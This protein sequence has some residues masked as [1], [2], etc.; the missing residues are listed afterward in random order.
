[1]AVDAALPHEEVAH[2]QEPGGDRVQSC[3]QGRQ[4]VDLDHRRATHTAAP[5][6]ASANANVTP[7]AAQGRA[8]ATSARP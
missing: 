4:I 7:Q 1:V 3:V 8:K 6:V 2:D 5:K